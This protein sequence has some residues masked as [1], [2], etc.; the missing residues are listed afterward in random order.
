[1]GAGR[2]KACWL[3]PPAS[4]LLCPSTVNRAPAQERHRGRDLH[5]DSGPPPSFPTSAARR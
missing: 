3:G 4:L 2:I 1:M 5:L